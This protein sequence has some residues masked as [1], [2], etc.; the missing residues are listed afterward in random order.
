MATTHQIA[1]ALKA[2]RKALKERDIAA[3]RKLSGSTIRMAAL[4]NGE[5]IFYVSLAEYMLSK[6]ITKGHYFRE[7]GR[8][9]FIEKVLGIIDAALV[10]LEGGRQDIY[11]RRIWQIITEMRQLESE[12]QRYVHGLETKSRT[13]LGSNL[14][15]EGFSLSRAAEI[16]GAD[17]RDIMQFSG[18]T[19]MSDRVGR[20]KLMK[21]RVEHVRKLFS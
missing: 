7:K 5:E 3:L 2:L 4:E 1:S 20:T 14:Y 16:T 8:Q 10:G 13:K 19:L 6:L 9:E 11:G 12:E 21:E 18:K 17:K 15:A